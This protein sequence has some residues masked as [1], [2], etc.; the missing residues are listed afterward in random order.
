MASISPIKIAL[1]RLHQK[2]NELIN[3]YEELND[4]LIP[5]KKKKEEETRIIDFKE[6]NMTIEE[7]EKRRHQSPIQ[8]DL[9]LYNFKLNKLIE[10]M[11]NL[12]ENELEI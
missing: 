1:T 12:Y 10:S 11:K 9:I 8:Q 6:S 3:I 2:I 7:S 4:K 5:I